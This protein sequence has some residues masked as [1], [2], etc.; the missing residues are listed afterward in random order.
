MFSQLGPLF[1]TVFRATEHAD[2]RLEIR[3]EEKENGRKK[4]EDDSAEAEESALWED[5]TGVSVSA[6]RTF[7]IEFLQKNNAPIEGVQTE[8]VSVTPTPQPAAPV[9]TVAAR[10]VKAYGAM[11][12][13]N[14]PHA[15]PPVPQTPAPEPSE[16][17]LASLLEANEIRQIHRLIAELDAL[18]RS[19]VETLSIQL[20]G[21]TFL[22]AVDAAVRLQ[23]NG[24]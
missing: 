12:A 15:A 21:G 14:T 2:A 8:T 18:S 7:L 4:H 17:D 23:K 6:L 9:S 11:A 10:A 13:Q 16:G 5:S 22:D 20:D 1:K 19:G 3:R 24:L